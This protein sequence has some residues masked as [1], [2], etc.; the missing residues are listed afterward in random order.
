MPWVDLVGSRWCVLGCQKG[1]GDQIEG[2]RG[3]CLGGGIEVGSLYPEGN[4]ASQKNFGGELG[5]STVM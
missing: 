2:S 3:R 1:V 5:E 4:N